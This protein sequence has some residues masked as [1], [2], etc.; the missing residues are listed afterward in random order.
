MWEVVGVNAYYDYSSS[1]TYQDNGIPVVEGV[2]VLDSTDPLCGGGPGPSAA[3]DDALSGHDRNLMETMR[4]E[5]EALHPDVEDQPENGESMDGNDDGV[6]AVQR[7]LQR[8]HA[9]T[10]GG[11]RAN[12]FGRGPRVQQTGKRGACSF[13]FRCLKNDTHPHVFVF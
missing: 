6:D 9:G 10:R 1:V 3:T 5:S 4:T 7:N 8:Y 13:T 12:Y 11:P 2:F